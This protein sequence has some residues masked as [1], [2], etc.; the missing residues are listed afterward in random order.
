MLRWC[1]V[2]VIAVLCGVVPACAAWAQSAQALA[3]GI[4][5]MTCEFEGRLDAA[6]VEYQ[7]SV[8][9][10][11]SVFKIQIRLGVVNAELGRHARAIKAFEAALRLVPSDIHVRYLLALSYT[12]ARDYAHAARQFEIILATYPADEPRKV[13]LHGYLGELYFLSGKTTDAIAQY[14]RLLLLEP[15]DTD[16]LVVVGS[17]YLEHDKKAE[18]MTLL[19]RCVE[20]DPSDV[21]CLNALGYSY[22]ED[23]KDLAVAEKLVVRALALKPGAAAFLDS[24]GWVYFKQGKFE[25]ALETLQ[26]AVEREKDP[27]IFDHIG[28][29]FEKLG[30]PGEALESWRAA[31]AIDRSMPGIISKI[32]RTEKLL[33]AEGH[34]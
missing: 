13:E 29:T 16:A 31:A 20:A 26:K 34:R 15:S 17:Y 1:V 11:P 28:D 32:S 9:S 2:T 12:A 7:E 33:H 22:A 6:A 27:V 21:D 30:R 10:D 4:M 14:E 8:R 19:E 18:G 24:L 5:G 25:L 23:G 3:H